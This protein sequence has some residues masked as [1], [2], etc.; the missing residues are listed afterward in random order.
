MTAK[1]MNALVRVG[2]QPGK[3][4]LRVMFRKVAQP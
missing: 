4:R 3:N 1:R 2:S